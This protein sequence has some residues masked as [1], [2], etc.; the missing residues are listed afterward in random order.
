M[1]VC[2]I[3][4]CQ[5]SIQGNVISGITNETPVSEVY[6]TVLKDKKTTL[7]D[8]T[9][10]ND[11]GSFVITD[12]EPNKLYKI[13]LSTFAYKDQIIEIKTNNGI[14]NT[15]LT[16]NTECEYTEQSAEKDWKNGNP[17]LLLFGS[18]APIGNSASDIKFEKKYAIEYFD[19]GCEPPIQECIKVYNERIFELMDKKYGMKW[20]KKVRSDVEYLN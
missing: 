13:K 11:D 1:L 20:R 3:S 7:K 14:I 10:T 2:G 5:V 4:Y 12:L 8:M 16:L 19:F 17:K 6:I 18:I 9:I 15:T